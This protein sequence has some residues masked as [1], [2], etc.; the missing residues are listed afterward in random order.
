MSDFYKAS[1]EAARIVREW[2]EEESP[3]LLERCLGMEL[4]CIMHYRNGNDLYLEVPSGSVPLDCTKVDDT[5]FIR[6]F[7]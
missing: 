2:N 6:G 4:M 7:Q 5:D 3:L 1:P